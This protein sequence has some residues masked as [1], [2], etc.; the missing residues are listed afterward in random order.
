MGVIQ[1]M[2]KNYVSILQNLRE[3]H[4]LLFVLH[5]FFVGGAVLTLL[6]VLLAGVLRLLGFS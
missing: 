5:I 4:T 3:G 6:L 2:L 1:K